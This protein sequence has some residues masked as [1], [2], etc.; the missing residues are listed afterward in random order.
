VT[1]LADHSGGTSC[2][3]VDLGC[4]GYKLSCTFGEK[5]ASPDKQLHYVVAPRLL[6][7]AVDGDNLGVDGWTK[8]IM[9]SYGEMSSFSAFMHDKTQ[10]FVNDIVAKHTVYFC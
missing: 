2:V 1:F 7:S 5:S 4:S 9:E 10:I 8:K 6:S 3:N